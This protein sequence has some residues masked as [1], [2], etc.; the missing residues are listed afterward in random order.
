[1]NHERRIQRAAVAVLAGLAIQLGSTLHWTPLTFVLFAAI[2]APL[3][4]LG[5][6]LYLATVWSIL[7][8]RNVL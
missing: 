6:G 7:K 3:V 5:V 4:L 8:E 2:G 1:M